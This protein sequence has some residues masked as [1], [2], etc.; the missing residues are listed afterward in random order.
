MDPVL[1]ITLRSALA[2]LFGAAAVHKLRAPAD[3]RD[4]LAGYRLVP[5]RA[6]GV[7]AIALALVEVATAA[8]FGLA[9][10]GVVAPVAA[11]SLLCVY[12]AAI[13]VNLARGR[14]DI[15]CGCG[16]TATHQ[17]LSPGLL[18]RNAVLAAGALLCLRSVD[19]RPLVWVDG[20]TVLGATGVLVAVY[21]SAN[22]LIA[23]APAWA[24]VRSAS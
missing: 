1:D 4:A 3:F 5:V 19:P 17:P 14:S 16:G 13:G 10:P 11:V 7:V 18:V 20:V 21:G 12:S 24:R 9:L 22:R 8:A 15:D 2:L 23:G 6:T